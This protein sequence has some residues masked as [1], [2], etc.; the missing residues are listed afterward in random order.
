MDFDGKPGEVF[1]RRAL[2]QDAIH[3][4]LGVVTG[5]VFFQRAVTLRFL[6]GA[7]EP[8]HIRHILGAFEQLL[9]V[10]N[11]QNDRNRFALARDNFRF[12]QFHAAKLA[13]STLFARGDS[14]ATSAPAPA[15]K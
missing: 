13:A 6:A 2:K 7:L 5:K 8:L 11:G 10:G 15:T 1:F 4:S 3:G 9:K 12:K 14:T